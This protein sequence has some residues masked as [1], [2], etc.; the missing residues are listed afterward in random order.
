MSMRTAKKKTS[1]PTER[2]NRNKQKEQMM[3]SVV[4][5]VMVI[6]VVAVSGCVGQSKTSGN[7]NV[8]PD[9]SQRSA[10]IGLSST[11]LNAIPTL[12]TSDCLKVQATK[13]NLDALNLYFTAYCKPECYASDTTVCNNLGLLSGAYTQLNP[14]VSACNGG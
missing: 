9:Q 12:S 2:A 3:F 8:C 4:V 10:M 11:T 13:Q 14:K 5:I 7:Q 1:R 6:S